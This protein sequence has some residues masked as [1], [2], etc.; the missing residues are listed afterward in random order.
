MKHF[1]AAL[2][3]FLIVLI[4]PSSIV[5]LRISN[6]VLQPEPLLHALDSTGAYEKLSTALVDMVFTEDTLVE[7][8]IPGVDAE[9]VSG[10]ARDAFSAEWT[11]QTLES[12]IGQVYVLVR[13]PEV[14]V[15]DVELVLPIQE[16]KRVL[17]EKVQEQTGTELPVEIV[18]SIPDEI[19]LVKLALSSEKDTSEGDTEKD[20]MEL[21]EEEGEFDLLNMSGA[22]TDEELEQLSDFD[23]ILEDVKAYMY[24]AQIA[25]WML[26]A[27]SVLLIGAIALLFMKNRVAQLAWSGVAF[28]LPGLFLFFIWLNIFIQ[29]K[30]NAQ[31]IIRESVS[32]VPQVFAD[33]LVS[34]SV[35]FVSSMYGWF[36][37]AGLIMV[38]IGVACIGLSFQQKS[39]SSR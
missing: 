14:Q 1:L 3:V 39:S 28:V 7:M 8:D 16:P 17:L 2:L 37:W 9:T 31:A 29:L 19:N 15:V 33:I 10:A 22:Y 13:E 35:E 32:E 26:I 38:V 20:R 21:G 30:G 12:V 34:L 5:V 27:F 36:L 25:L 18:D 11:K 6:Y 4:I 23:D 24:V